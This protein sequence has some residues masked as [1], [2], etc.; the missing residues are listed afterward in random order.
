MSYNATFYNSTEFEGQLNL[1]HSL[2]S[3]RVCWIQ[4][5]MN[6]K[7]YGT[8]ICMRAIDSLLPSK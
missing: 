8:Y 4:K 2:Q 6:G 5:G 3:S 7:Y 1:S